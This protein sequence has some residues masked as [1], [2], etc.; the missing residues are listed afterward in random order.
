MHEANAPL[1]GVGGDP[2]L[3]GR[4]DLRNGLDT[5][6]FGKSRR[7]RVHVEHDPR[8]VVFARQLAGNVAVC[9]FEC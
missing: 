2:E 6:R 9:A 8:D 5:L 4:F 7:Q 3:L 1:L